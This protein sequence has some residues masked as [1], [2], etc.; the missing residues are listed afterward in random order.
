MSSIAGTG[1]EGYLDGR[2][3]EAQFGQCWGIAVVSDGTLFVSEHYADVIRRI[4]DG[5]VTTLAGKCGE[6]RYLDGKGEEAR[7]K[8]PRGLCLDSDGSLLVADSRNSRIRRVSMD[9]VVTTVA[10]SG[11]QGDKDGELN[12]AQFNSPEE[13]CRNGDVLYVAD[14][15]ASCVKKIS[16]GRVVSL[17]GIECPSGVAFLN[18]EL[19]TLSYSKNQIF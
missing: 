4:K 14:F 5:V 9:G 17:R 10:G 18:G 8:G 3:E 7:F 16:N 11:E 13:I 15:N 1:E 19:F 12:Q 2:A 6:Y